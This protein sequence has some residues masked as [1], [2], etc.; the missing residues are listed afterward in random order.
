[1]GTAQ[2]KMIPREHGAY[3]ELLF[4]I[5][6][7]FLGGSPTTSTWLLAVGAIACFLA[8]EPANEPLLVLVG[9]RGNRTKR[10]ESDRA[11]RALLLFFLV[12]IGAGVAGLLLA[13]TAVQYAVSVPLLLGA[14]LMML[15]VQGLE[16]SMLGEGLA[17]ATLSSIAIPLGLSAGLGLRATLAVVLIWLVTSLLGT[18][19][20][21]LTIAR[22]KAKT[23]E[24][25]A[26][27][28]FK[29]ALLVLVC[30]AIIAVGVIA[31]YGSRVGLWILAA[32]VPVA[33]V[34]LAMAALRPTARRLRLMGW[35]LVAA[36]LCSL[37]AVVI[38]LKIIQ[39]FKAVEPTLPFPMF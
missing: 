22:T 10:E 29:R 35:S 14:G 13:T 26:R 8:N 16:R 11:K 30:L 17:A 39:D 3:A 37:I 2:R 38:T 21:R 23:D 32:A 33:L 25:F 6:T 5:V 20:V 27:V 34:V 4:P 7:V 31:P 1:M 15:A 28:R 19:E 12:A 9:Q 24:E 36:N 18:A